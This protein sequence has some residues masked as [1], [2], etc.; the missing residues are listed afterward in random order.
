MTQRNLKCD[1]Y[2][3]VLHLDAPTFGSLW[4]NYMAQR[5]LCRIPVHGLRVVFTMIHL[6]MKIAIRVVT[7]CHLILLASGNTWHHK[8]EPK[9]HG[10][11][12]S[13]VIWHRRVLFVGETLGIRSN[14]EIILVQVVH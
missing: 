4:L 14:N 1:A 2:D 13:E 7:P 11:R 5:L 9:G 8:T 10:G 3:P 6:A 12:S